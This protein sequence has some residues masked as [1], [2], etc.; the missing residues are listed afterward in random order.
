MGLNY[1]DNI[2]MQ[3]RERVSASDLP[4][5]DVRGLFRMY[6]VLLLAKGT[7]VTTEDVHNA[8]AAWMSE[9]DPAHEAIV[10]FSRL[11][12][13][14]ALDDLPYAEAIRITAEVMR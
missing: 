12:K 11:P 9:K 14:V 8:W 3:I 13:C 6:A 10:P 7:A 5:E 4:D 2:A 1:L